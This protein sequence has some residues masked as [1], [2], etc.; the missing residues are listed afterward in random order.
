MTASGNKKRG[1][2]KVGIFRKIRGGGQK[3]V[4]EKTKG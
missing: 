1:G 3:K 4:G 2:K